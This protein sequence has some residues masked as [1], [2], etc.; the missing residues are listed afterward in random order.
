MAAA[1]GAVAGP[2][3]QLNHLIRYPESSA[4]RFWSS[5]QQCGNRSLI[6]NVSA[7]LQC[8]HGPLD[9]IAPVL[10]HQSEW[11]QLALGCAAA[12]AS[13]IFWMTGSSR[14]AKAFGCSMFGI[15]ARMHCQGPSNACVSIE[16]ISAC[17]WQT[18]EH[19]AILSH[20]FQESTQRGPKP[21]IEKIAPA[22][23]NNT[24]ST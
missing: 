9:N 19:F 14:A 23:A 2:R 13:T 4:V 21:G 20:I 8:L 3:H 16:N 11:S 7:W 10:A 12:A 6:M 1:P 15:A 22:A 17:P 5:G 18:T 24:T